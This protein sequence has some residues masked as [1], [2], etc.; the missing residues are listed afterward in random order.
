METDPIAEERG[1]VVYVHVEDN[2][3]EVELNDIYVGRVFGDESEAYHTL[4]RKGLA[5]VE[6]ELQNLEQ[7]RK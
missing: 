2:V 1:E 6:A 3:E 5:S 4:W 7:I